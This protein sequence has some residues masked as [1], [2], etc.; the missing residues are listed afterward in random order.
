MDISKNLANNRTLRYVLPMFKDYGS[1]FVK[2][3]NK[4]FKLGIGINDAIL[5]INEVFDNHIFILIDTSIY[6][7]KIFIDFLDFIRKQL[8][9]EKDYVYDDVKTGNK[10]MII[11]KV[12]EKNIDTFRYFKEGAYSCMYAGVLDDYFAKDDDRLL[13]F[14]KDPKAQINF[15][16]KLKEDFNV[17]YNTWDLEVD[18]PISQFEETFNTI[19]K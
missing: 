17:E 2:K 11:I 13:I 5:P 6:E 4:V 10:H 16:K 15:I 9:F 8:Y 14:N 19:K 1:D 12:P 7:K 3:V 18:Y